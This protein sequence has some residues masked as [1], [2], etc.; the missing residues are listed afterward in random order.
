MDKY[1]PRDDLVSC[2]NCGFLH[3]SGCLCGRLSISIF[4]FQDAKSIF[5]PDTTMSLWLLFS[6]LFPVNCYNKVREETNALRSLIG[7]RLP[8]DSE[9]QFHY[10]ND[11]THDSGA[12][13]VRCVEVN[14]PRPSWFPAIF[15]RTDSDPGNN[16][17]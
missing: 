13:P 10:S 8:S 9:V 14:R 16:G 12:Y 15:R 1:K 7:D 17:S 5:F 3:P 11:P 2:P 6:C 4:F